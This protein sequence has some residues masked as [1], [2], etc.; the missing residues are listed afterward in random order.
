M[1]FVSFNVQYG[2]GLDGN[3]DPNRIV[4][5]VEGADVIALQEV[6]RNLPRNSLADLP[7]IFSGLMP[8]F[9]H[10]FGASATTDGGSSVVD[11]RMRMRFTEFGNMILSRHPILATRNILLPRSRTYDRLNIQRSALECLIDAPGGAIRAYSVHLDHRSPAERIAQIGFLKDCLSNYAQDGGAVTGGGEFGFPELPHTDDFVVMGD[12][13][14]MPEQPEYLAMV[15]P[16]DL[17]YGRTASTAFP[18]DALDAFG[19]RAQ[20][21]YTWEE[22]GQPDV[23]QYLDYC[24]VSGTLVSRLKDG[25]VDADCIASDHKPVWVELA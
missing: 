3:F 20:D 11:G 1:K 14:M 25:W 21:D 17:Y 2:F 15:G 13:N 5:A 10:A 6:T 16:R 18:I 4:A 22:P 24:F 8:K 12:F 9:Y 19:K 7:D 23:R